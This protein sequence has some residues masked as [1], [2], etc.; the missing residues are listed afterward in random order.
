MKSGP[1]PKSEAAWQSLPPCRSTTERRLVYAHPRA[2]GA[3]REVCREDVT[4]A[5]VATAGISAMMT[6]RRVRGAIPH[7]PSAGGAGAR[8]PAAGPI[9]PDIAV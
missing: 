9:V 5:P 2:I 8:S 3:T 6:A 7:P 1:A 4:I